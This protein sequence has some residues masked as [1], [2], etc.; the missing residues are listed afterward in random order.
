MEV[1]YICGK[2]T[3]LICKKCDEPYCENHASVYNQFTQ[4]DYDCCSKCAESL[5][6]KENE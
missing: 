1:C 3:D 6:C 2:E 5:K 4:I